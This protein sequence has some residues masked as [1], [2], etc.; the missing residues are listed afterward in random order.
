MTNNK[1]YVVVFCVRVTV[2]TWLCLLIV[3]VDNNIDVYKCINNIK[4]EEDIYW[5][6]TIIINAS[7]VLML[8]SFLCVGTTV[9][10]WVC[11]LNSK[12]R[13]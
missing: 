4:E 1:K 8:C 7:I 10:I 9:E 12:D 11:L 13:Q 2:D 3:K 6:T 5:Q